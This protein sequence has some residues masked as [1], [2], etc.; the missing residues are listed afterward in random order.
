MTYHYLNRKNLFKP[1]YW[2][3]VCLIAVFSAS[4]TQAKTILVHGDSLSAGYGITPEESW[5]T[6]LAEHYGDRH[7]VINASISGET[8]R[9]GLD[10]LSDL[11]KTHQPDVVVLELG[12]NDG[13]RGYPIPQIAKNLQEMIDLAKANNAQVIILG[14]RL[15][16]NLGKRYTTPFF[17]NYARLAKSNALAYLPFLLDNV[18]QYSELMQSDGLHPTAEAQPLILQN[19]LPVLDQALKRAAAS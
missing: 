11:L 14:I 19:V 8:S 9:G 4:F 10:R 1:I 17:E 5:V 7:Q 2:G 3:L 12:A 15:P 18:A 6:L 13:L 16:P